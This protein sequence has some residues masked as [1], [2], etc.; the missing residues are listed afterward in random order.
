MTF[1][2]FN[3]FSENI[4][5]PVLMNS[6]NEWVDDVITYNFLRHISFT[7]VCKNLIFQLWECRDLA[8]YPGQN[9]WEIEAMVYGWYILIQGYA[10][11]C[12]WKKMKIFKIS[13]IIYMTN[14]EAMTSTTLS[15]E[16]F[17]RTGQE[18][19]SEKIWNFKM[20]QLPVFLIRFS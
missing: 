12:I 17:I 10:F 4:S 19:F 2:K 6:S 7:R 5:W 1:W 18:M 9:K 16:S 3:F 13:C 14:C 8:L 15:F 11:T 20:S